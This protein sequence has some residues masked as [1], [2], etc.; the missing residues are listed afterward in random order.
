MADGNGNGKKAKVEEVAAPSP[1]AEELAAA[2][3]PEELTPAVQAILT[4]MAATQQ[5]LVAAIA[6]GNAA[7]APVAAQGSREWAR[8]DAD[9]AMAE[10]HGTVSTGPA[11][12]GDDL[13]PHEVVFRSSD[14]T[15][16]IIRKSRHRITLPTGEAR[17]SEGVHYT[18]EGGE[19]RTRSADV[20]RYLKSR[21]GFNLTF[22]LVGEEP[23]RIPSPEGVLRRVMQAMRDLD[24]ETLDSI[25]RE[26]RQGHKRPIVLDS[27]T[28]ARELLATKA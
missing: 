10:L 27:I 12:E 26:E 5:Q 7:P 6:A 20:V 19:F 1:A 18:F 24:V 9:D 13:L 25:D 16:N 14:K 2:I 3:P 17:V 4:Q 22:W 8:M 23:D 21:P 15:H 28:S 11:P